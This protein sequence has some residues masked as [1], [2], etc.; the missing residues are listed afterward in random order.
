M[1]VYLFYD[2]PMYRLLTRE[3]I[4]A[5][6]G[7]QSAKVCELLLLGI[8]GSNLKSTMNHDAEV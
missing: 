4:N 5:I 7:K 2:P 8:V 3:K 6:W 1:N